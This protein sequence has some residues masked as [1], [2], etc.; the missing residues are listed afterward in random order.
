MIGLSTENLYR[1]KET[2]VL[3]RVSDVQV[4]KDQDITSVMPCN[5]HIMVILLSGSSQ[6]FNIPK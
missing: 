3:D 6:N 1:G 2:A 5:L 4:S